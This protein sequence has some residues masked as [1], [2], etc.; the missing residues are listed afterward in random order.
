MNFGQLQT[1]VLSWLDDPLAGY[2]TIPQI[3][4]WLNNAQR[5]AQKQLIQAGSN[6]YVISA[7][8]NLIQDQDT[9]VQP[10]NF[11]K[12]NRFLVVLSGTGVNTN[13]QTMSFAPLIQLQTS[14]AIQ[15]PPSAYAI[16]KNCFQVRPFPDQNYEV[17]LDYSYRVGDM[18]N[19]LDVPDVPDQYQEYIA[20]LAT[21]DGFLKDQRDP[22]PFL[23]K[24]Q[25]YLDLMKQDAED[26]Y[27]DQPKQ[28]LC[29]DDYSWGYNF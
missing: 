27:Q 11:L 8:T 17:Q 21:L 7:H 25:Y 13:Y 29:V 10:E 18:T 9:Y 12:V 5:E 2:F 26:R 24:R 3:S 28:V 22:T 14:Y 4:V 6:W 16:K 1:L 23:T 15:G 19:A 20:V